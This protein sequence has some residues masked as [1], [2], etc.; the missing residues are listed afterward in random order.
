[1]KGNFRGM[2]AVLL[3]MGCMVGSSALAADEV[4]AAGS[5]QY[6]AAVL[7]CHAAYVKEHV[8]TRLRLG[9]DFTDFTASEVAHAAAAD[10]RAP[11]QAYARYMHE[12]A[13]MTDSKDEYMRAKADELRQYAFD[14]TIDLMIRARE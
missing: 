6:E 13:P 14:Y 10:C 1:M 3:V 8:A 12:Q 4:A 7:K 11:M 2:T 5:D 9:L